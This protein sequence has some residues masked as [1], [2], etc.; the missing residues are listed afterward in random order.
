MHRVKRAKMIRSPNII[1]FIS[2]KKPYHEIVGQAIRSFLKQKIPWSPDPHLIDQ[3]RLLIKGS[4]WSSLETQ[5]RGCPWKR[6][7][8]ILARVELASRD[9]R[10]DLGRFP[11]DVEDVTRMLIR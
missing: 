8:E 9:G 4:M 6:R 11:V 10:F 7:A 1:A 3:H 5:K 2:I